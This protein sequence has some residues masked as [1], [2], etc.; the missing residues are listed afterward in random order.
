MESLRGLGYMSTQFCLD[1]PSGLPS[2]SSLAVIKKRAIPGRVNISHVF[3]MLALM[4]KGIAGN[5]LQPPPIG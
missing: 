2:F 4:N 3:E 5:F 1:D